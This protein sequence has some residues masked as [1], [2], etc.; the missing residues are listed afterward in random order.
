[1]VEIT[2]FGTP[3]G[4]ARAQSSAR[5][6]PMVPPIATMPSI[7]PCRYN[8]LVSNAAPVAMI[9]MAVFSS[10][11]SLALA[12][13]DPAATATSC[14]VMP[15]C[16][17]GSPSTLTSMVS[18]TQPW[19]SIRSTRYSNSSDFV[20]NVPTTR[21]VF[22]SLMVPRWNVCAAAGAYS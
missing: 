21:M 11:D 5:S 8:S 2:N 15:T 17:F 13:L 4:S 16:A 12:M 9:C 7:W 19:L 3:S 22:C 20:S 6:V 1:M 10:P 14:L 18:A